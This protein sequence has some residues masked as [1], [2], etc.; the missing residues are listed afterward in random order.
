MAG[1]ITSTNAEGAAGA[2]HEPAPEPQPGATSAP[3]RRL[4]LEALGLTGTSAAILPPL[5]DA[6]AAGAPADVA[7]LKAAL[8]A[9]DV[10]LGL[11]PGGAVADQL[12]RLVH[13]L[14]PL[15]SQATL[16][17]DLASDGSLDTFWL[18]DVTSDEQDW[19]K[20]LHALRVRLGKRFIARGPVRVRLLVT[21][22]SARRAGNSQGGL[23]F[24]LS[25]I[26]SPTLHTLHVRV[27]GQSPL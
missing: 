5:R 23:D 12:R 21:S 18:E 2:V 3:G 11:G 24:D 19:R 10:A 14:A 9:H 20:A 26:G 13:D 17:V 6:A 27:L 15:G 4:S 22:R 16:A 1:V 8:A 7:G 25:N